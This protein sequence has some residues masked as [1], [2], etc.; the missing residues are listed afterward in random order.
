MNTDYY[1]VFLKAAETKNISRAAEA[2]GYL[3][4]DYRTG[5]G[6]GDIRQSVL[7]T[8]GL[9]A[10]TLK[11]FFAEKHKQLTRLT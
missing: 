5:R 7:K 10:M 4:A 8:A 3:S 2:L 6:C 9:T 1:K 11:R